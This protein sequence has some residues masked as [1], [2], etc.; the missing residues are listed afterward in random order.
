MQAVVAIAPLK[1][2]TSNDKNRQSKQNTSKDFAKTFFAKVL[3]DACEKEQQRNIEI[4]TSGYTKDALPFYN[5]V[6]MREY[7]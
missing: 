2:V 6:N 7:C 5:F 4:Q 1:K 3:D